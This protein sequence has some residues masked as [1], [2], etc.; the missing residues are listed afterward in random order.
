MD[1]FLF[2]LTE[3]TSISSNDLFLKDSSL[4]NFSEKISAVN[5]RKGLCDLYDH[6]TIR[7]SDTL[8][9][10]FR[11]AIPSGTPE[12]IAA[13]SFSGYS[14]IP[15]TIEYAN[16][17][18]YEKSSIKA[19]PE[20]L[21]KFDP[22][23]YLITC[24]FLILFLETSNNEPHSLYCLDWGY[25]GG[26]AFLEIYNDTYLVANTEER[27]FSKSFIYSNADTIRRPLIFAAVGDHAYF[28]NAPILPSQQISMNVITAT[29]IGEV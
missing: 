13:F 21:L 11:I 19:D 17:M 24:S 3:K 10:P 5:L 28:Y 27:L 8:P 20:G 4:S 23:L 2:E 18:T 1:N 25:P 9:S 6:V 7:L 22:G 29:R 12:N 16:G 26:N 14:S 15:V